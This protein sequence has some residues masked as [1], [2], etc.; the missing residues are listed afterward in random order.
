MKIGDIVSSKSGL[1][2]TEQDGQYGVVIDI[3]AKYPHHDRDDGRVVKV[4]WPGKTG[5]ARISH[6]ELISESR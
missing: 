3:F 2:F 1:N 5:L 4:A 6:L